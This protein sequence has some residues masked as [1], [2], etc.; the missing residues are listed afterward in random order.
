[1]IFMKIPREHA[2]VG[3]AMGKYGVATCQAVMPEEYRLQCMMDPAIQPL[4]H[5]IR[6]GGPAV[7]AFNQPGDNMMIYRAILSTQPG[8][9]LVLRGDPSQVSQW[10]EQASSWAHQRGVVGCIVDG[11]TRDVDKIRELGFPVWTRTIHAGQSMKSRLGSVNAPIVCG[12]VLVHAGDII[13]ADGDGVLVV[14]WQIAPEIERL[15]RER[16]EYEIIA[17]KQFLA[18]ENVER[19]DQRERTLQ[20]LRPTIVDGRWDEHIQGEPP[21]RWPSIA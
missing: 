16:Y 3:A 14:P 7:T 11:A 17:R 12:N 20:S 19:M 21:R 2:A 13:V 8:D 6:A 18:G 1:L 15:A 4:M 10:G 9:V 5:K